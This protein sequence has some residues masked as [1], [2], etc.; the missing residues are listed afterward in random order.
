MIGQAISHYRILEKL[1]EVPNF[2]V[3]VLARAV[4]NL[5]IPPL[6]GGSCNGRCI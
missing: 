3:S 2:P 5:R 1:G 4:E 6:C